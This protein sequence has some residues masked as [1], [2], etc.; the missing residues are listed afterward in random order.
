MWPSSC[1]IVEVCTFQTTTEF[2]TTTVGFLSRP[3]HPDI[4]SFSIQV[5][6]DLY[7]SG[8][9]VRKTLFPERAVQ[10]HD[11]WQV[12]TTGCIKSFHVVSVWSNLF[13]PVS[14]KEE[15]VN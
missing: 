3:D 1:K 12:L 6:P 9:N 2:F 11:T 7:F 14:K 5:T 8:S 10:L 13:T 15:E 4:P